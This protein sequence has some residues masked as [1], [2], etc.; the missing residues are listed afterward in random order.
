MQKI[1]AFFKAPVYIVLVEHGTT[2]CAASRISL[3]ERVRAAEQN[4]LS[5]LSIRLLRKPC[6][7][8]KNAALFSSV[9]TV[10]VWFSW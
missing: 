9:F 8:G 1:F 2:Y 10:C 5:Y 3:R 4:Q 6:V 7:Q